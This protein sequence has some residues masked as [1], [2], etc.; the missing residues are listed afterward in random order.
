LVRGGSASIGADVL[1]K[2]RDAVSG[3]DT[4]GKLLQFL[5]L[6]RTCSKSLVKLQSE[7]R[8]TLNL[9]A[10]L[11]QFPISMEI[12]SELQWQREREDRARSDYQNHQRELIARISALATPRRLRGLGS[13]PAGRGTSDKDLAF[14]TPSASRNDPW[15]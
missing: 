4:P 6:H 15:V 8:K 9:L 12:G 7:S 1:S 11:T 2:S 14:F 13:G 5:K 10:L 3:F